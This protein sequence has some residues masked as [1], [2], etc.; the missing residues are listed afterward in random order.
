MEA[1]E[2]REFDQ[3]Q[4]VNAPLG[5]EEIF[6]MPGRVQPTIEG[7]TRRA[8]PSVGDVDVLAPAPDVAGLNSHL[9]RIA[10]A[11]RMREDA[12]SFD[13]LPFQPGGGREKR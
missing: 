13:G 7:D 8:E 9:V 5:P 2:G 12:A 10:A 6:A 3:V 1:G 11:R 4:R